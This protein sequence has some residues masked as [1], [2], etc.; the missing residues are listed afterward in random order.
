MAE[1]QRHKISINSEATLNFTIAAGADS[2]FMTAD[3]F[4]I[5]DVY[6]E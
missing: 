2:E 4:V 1:T 3:A 6:V 5:C